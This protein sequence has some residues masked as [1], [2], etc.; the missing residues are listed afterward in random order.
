MQLQYMISFTYIMQK[1]KGTIRVIKDDNLWHSRSKKDWIL[2]GH[3]KE[4]KKDKAVLIMK[5]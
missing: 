3:W 1:Y 5:M 2:D 4:N